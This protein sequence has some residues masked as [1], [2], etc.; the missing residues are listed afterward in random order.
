[1]WSHYAEGYKGV[2]IGMDTVKAGYENEE[3]YAIPAHRGEMIYVNTAP[4]SI[5][6]ISEDDLMAIGDSSIINWKKQ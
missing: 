6:M 5:N 1:M 3:L 2:V 4:K